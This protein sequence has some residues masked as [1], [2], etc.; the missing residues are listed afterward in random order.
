M[1]ADICISHLRILISVYC[2]SKCH[3]GIHIHIAMHRSQSETQAHKQTDVWMFSGVE[4]YE[5][6]SNGGRCYSFSCYSRAIGYHT[7]EWKLCKNSLFFYLYSFHQNM[8]VSLITTG[9]SINY[10]HTITTNKYTWVQ[11]TSANC[12]WKP[13]S[14]L[15]LVKTNKILTLCC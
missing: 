1:P 9:K 12:Y 4:L 8:D 6:F 2:S 7:Y 15:T 14:S 3:P 5:D 13:S 11:I 10:I